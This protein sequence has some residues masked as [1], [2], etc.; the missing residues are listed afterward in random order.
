MLLQVL[1]V[2]TVAEIGLGEMTVAL[3]CA[4]QALLASVT[5]TVYIPGERLDAVAVVWLGLVFHVYE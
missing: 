5:V 4:I 1:Y 3:A 2:V